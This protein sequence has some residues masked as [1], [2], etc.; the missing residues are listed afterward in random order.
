[1]VIHGIWGGLEG[2]EKINGG[3]VVAGS[4]AVGMVAF[5]VAVLIEND[6]MGSSFLEGVMMMTSFSL[7]A[8]ILLMDS[9]ALI[10]FISTSMA[11]LA[12]VAY[13]RRL[14]TASSPVLPSRSADCRDRL[15]R[16]DVVGDMKFVVF[17]RRLIWGSEVS[18]AG[19]KE[20]LLG[21]RRVR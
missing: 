9:K 15:L 6:S 21:L 19:R 1:M 17:G 12:I 20:L 14:A 13:A 3:G 10:A 2:G 4:G 16:E 11:S 18:R 5:G 7:D 8:E